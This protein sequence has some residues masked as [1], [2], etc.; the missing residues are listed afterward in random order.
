MFTFPKSSDLNVSYVYQAKVVDENKSTLVESALF[1]LERGVYL[2]P[3]PCISDS[4]GSSQGLSIGASAGLTLGLILG[5]ALLALG[6]RTL[7]RLFLQ[8]SVVQRRR[9]SVRASS[10][11]LGRQESATQGL[12]LQRMAGRVPLQADGQHGEPL[13]QQPPPPYSSLPRYVYTSDSPPAW[14]LVTPGRGYESSP[15]RP[16]SLRPRNSSYDSMGPYGSSI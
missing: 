15:R 8:R 10:R 2:A 16:R 5:V 12:E 7:H 13:P 14:P 1:Y 3:T 9:A 6:G 4:S 11:H